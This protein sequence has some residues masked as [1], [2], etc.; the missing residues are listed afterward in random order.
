MRVGGDAESAAF[1]GI[2]T[3]RIKLFALMISGFTGR[4]RRA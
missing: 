1:A 4:H 3:G 2:R